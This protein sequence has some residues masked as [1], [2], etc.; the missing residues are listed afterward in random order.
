METS[1]IA[2]DAGKGLR[3]ALLAALLAGAVWGCAPA[4]PQLQAQQQFDV[5][6]TYGAFVEQRLDACSMAI[7]SE[8]TSPERRA[9]ALISRGVLRAEAGQEARAIAD[10]GRALRINPANASAYFERGVVH[11]NRG[12]FENA[13]RD[14]D[15]A[16]QLQ[17]DMTAAIERR[18]QA[19]TGRSQG[20]LYEIARLDAALARTP[21]DPTLFNSRCWTRAINDDD[22]DAA[23]AD[24]NEAI[25]LSPSFAAALDS[26]GLVHL[27]R[28]DYALAVADYEAALAVEPGS[29]HYL[30]GRGLARIRLGLEAEG[31]AD[32]NQAAQLA[33]E[34]PELYGSYGA[35]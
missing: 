29:A 3:A 34:T 27:K 2:P 26:R 9:L 17:P 5:C 10:F 28:G 11:H 14:Y 21:G 23:L 24:C 13:V 7:V 30:Y 33:P 4:D 18:E 6:E 19:L 16:L 20:Y 25:R 1:A 32:L 12:A 15:R 35:L 22:L 31:Q 8:H